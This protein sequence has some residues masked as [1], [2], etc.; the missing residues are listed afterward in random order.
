[1]LFSILG[2]YVGCLQLRF[3]LPS[4]VTRY[5]PCSI[6]GET[7]RSLMSF[8]RSLVFPP[9]PNYSILHEAFVAGDC[10][11]GAVV[12]VVTLMCEFFPKLFE[13]S[14]VPR[15]AIVVRCLLAELLLATQLF[16]LHFEPAELLFTKPHQETLF[17]G[18]LH[19]VQFERTLR[20]LIVWHG[21]SA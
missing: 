17:S 1:V 12:A 5:D 18:I 7:H 21:V 19:H 8:N 15:Y 20:S 11:P 16:D 13:L 3:V 6:G 14:K 2:I 4:G 10:G 9:T